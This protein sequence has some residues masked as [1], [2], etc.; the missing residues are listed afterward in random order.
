MLKPSRMCTHHVC[1]L[2]ALD[3]SGTYV[4]VGGEGCQMQIW[5]LDTRK[6]VFRAKG[7]KPNRCGGT[8]AGDHGGASAAQWWFASM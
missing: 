6:E 7:G 3:S 5:N 2:Q 1:T 8:G 4:A